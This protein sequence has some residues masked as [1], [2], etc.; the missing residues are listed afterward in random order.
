MPRAI[1]TL[2][3]ELFRTITWDHGKE[4]ARHATFT[5]DTGIQIYF[6]D[7]HSAG[8]ARTPTAAAPLPASGPPTSVH[9]QRDLAGWPAASTTGLARPSDT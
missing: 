8:R 2:R 9:S 7:P 1:A 6:C 3:G 5:M 4:M